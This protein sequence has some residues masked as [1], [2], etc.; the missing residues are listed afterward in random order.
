[1][2]NVMFDVNAPKPVHSRLNATIAEKNLMFYLSATAFHTTTFG[3]MSF[4]FRFRRIS[5][6]PTLAIG[7]VYFSVFQNVNNI[8]YK[9]IVDQA[10]IN[11][12]RKLGYSAQVQPLGT[13]KN[14]GFN[15]V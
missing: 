10:V 7:T 12:T 6:V 9:L 15:Y 5:L 1:M 4:F 2:C 11:E 3:W 14:R 8:L 13:R